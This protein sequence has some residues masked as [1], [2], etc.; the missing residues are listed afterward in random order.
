M[1]RQ[2]ERMDQVVQKVLRKSLSSEPQQWDL[3]M[4]FVEFAINNTVHTGR[5]ESPFFVNNGVHPRML[6]INKLKAP[7]SDDIH[8]LQ[9]VLRAQHSTLS[10]VKQVPA[11]VR[12]G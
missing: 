5:S 7:H 12:S 9:D 2:T 8:V 1:G 11:A 4:P 3:L 6:I 10:A